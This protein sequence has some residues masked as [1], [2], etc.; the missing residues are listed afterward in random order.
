ME[1]QNN[2]NK[3]VEPKVQETAINQETNNAA[4][5]QAKEETSEV[6]QT[7]AASAPVQ[8]NVNPNNRRK[9]RRKQWRSRIGK[10]KD[11]IMNDEEKRKKSVKMGVT[12]IILCLLS[13][14][15]V[16]PFM[17]LGAQIVV[18]AFTHFMFVIGNLVVAVLGLALP[19]ILFY[20]QIFQVSYMVAQLSIRKDWFG[21]VCLVFSI[22][23]ILGIIVLGFFSIQPV[24]NATFGA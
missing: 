12:S 22:L 5:V 1:N 13:L 24:L 14:A 2:E 11:A 6:V 4:N 21:W 18:Y 17:W 3:V 23:T 16:Y 9:R 20:G 15:L 8:E 19:T 10:Q 7:S